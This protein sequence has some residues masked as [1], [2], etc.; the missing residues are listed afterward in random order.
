METFQ[1]DYLET[2][3]L[4]LRKITPEVIDYLFANLEDSAIMDAM[5]IETPESLAKEKEKHAGGLKTYNR[6]VIN[7]IMIDKETGASIGACG[8]HSW[9]PD[10]NRAEIGYALYKEAYKQKGYMTEA[11]ATILHYAFTAMNLHR[12][13][14]LT[15]TYNTPS[16]KILEH[17]GFTF[18]G[19]LRQH[20]N[21]DGTMEDS[22]L[23]SLLKNEY[24][25][26]Y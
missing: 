7:F 6:T 25:P 24:K 14:A 22:I 10:H 17:F 19:T 21:V 18:E 15:A 9:A 11:V 23:F 20:Y 4:K 13:E 8:F 16:I 26:T 1:F 2:P 5:G 3:R 12:V